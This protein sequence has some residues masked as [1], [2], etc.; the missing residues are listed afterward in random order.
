MLIQKPLLVNNKTPENI[1]FGIM[2]LSLWEFSL[3]TKQHGLTSGPAYLFAPEY[4]ESFATSKDG[5]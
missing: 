2:T 5:R 4:T 1:Y 3:T